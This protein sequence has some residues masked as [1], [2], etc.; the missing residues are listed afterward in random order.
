MWRSPWGTS[1]TGEPGGAARLRLRAPI[2][3]AGR[4]GQRRT[5]RGGLA[6]LLLIGSAARR[7]A[8]R[9]TGRSVH[10]DAAA[11]KQRRPGAAIH[12]ETPPR[13]PRRPRILRRRE[14]DFG[15]LSL[16]PPEGGSAA[17]AHHVRRATWERKHWPTNSSAATVSAS[18]PSARAS[19]RRGAASSCELSTAGAASVSG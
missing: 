9:T 11:R 1:G 18:R 13:A 6:L 19:L 12:S 14:G 2:T 4:H 3:F 15:T 8:S 16:W 5:T 7:G 10:R 17:P